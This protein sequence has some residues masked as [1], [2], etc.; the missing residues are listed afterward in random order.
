METMRLSFFLAGFRVRSALESGLGSGVEG[1]E[2]KFLAGNQGAIVEE[3]IVIVQT[4]T[5]F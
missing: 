2:L 1:S 3:C 5:A 4:R